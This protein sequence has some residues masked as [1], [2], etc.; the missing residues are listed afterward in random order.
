MDIRYPLERLYKGF[1]RHTFQLVTIDV[2]Y[3]LCQRYSKRR[4]TIVMSHQTALLPHIRFPQLPHPRSHALPDYNQSPAR[5][6]PYFPP[7]SLAEY[8]IL[9]TKF[10]TTAPNNITASTVGPNL[11]SK[12]ACPRARMLFARQWYVTS[13]YSS[14][15]TDTP[16]K[17]KA[18]MKAGRSPKLSMPRERAPRTTVKLSHER[19]VRSFAKKTF[20]S[21]RVGRAIRLPEGVC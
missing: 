19:K 18:E 3:I 16:V 15:K 7:P 9:S 5:N 17:K 1:W 20:G 14:V 11:S 6:N 8:T 4:A 10:T 21:T 2:Y 13:A 12:P